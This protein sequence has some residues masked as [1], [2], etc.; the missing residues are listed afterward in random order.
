PLRLRRGRIAAVRIGRGRRAAGGMAARADA[1]RGERGERLR[2]KTATAEDDFW[3]D[4]ALA[5]GG[6]VEEV[7]ERVSE[8]E[9]THWIDWRRR[10][11][12]LSLHRRLD[13]LFAHQSVLLLGALAKK[14]NGQPFDIADT[15]IQ[16]APKEE[17]EATPENVLALFK[18]MKKG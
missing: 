13:Y 6:T 1:A 9:R 17:P 4:L 18:S 2:P 14:Q 12:P 11:G 8:E 5:F 7:T 3:A 15:L 10:H 16:W